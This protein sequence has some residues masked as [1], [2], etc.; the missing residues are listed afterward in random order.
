MTRKRNQARYRLQLQTKRRLQRARKSKLHRLSWLWSP[1]GAFWTSVALLC[2]I[3]G[4]Y[5]LFKSSVSLEP[6][7]P[8]DSE[9]ALTFPFRVTNEGVLPIYSVTR[10]LPVH[11]LINPSGGGLFDLTLTD[12]TAPIPKLSH[13][14]SFTISINLASFP[15]RTTGDVEIQIDYNTL[16][17]R[18]TSELFRFVARV[19]ADGTVYW[20]HKALSE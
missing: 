7:I 16:I 1:S 19:R 6:D 12:T 11:Q 18:H 13:K 14:E 15:P 3:V 10:S 8:I 17:G 20:Y 2:A 4:T 9:R 5:Y